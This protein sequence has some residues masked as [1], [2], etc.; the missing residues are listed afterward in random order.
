MPVQDGPDG[1]L[2]QAAVDRGPILGLAF[3]REPTP[4]HLS[5]IDGRHIGKYTAFQD[6]HALDWTLGLAL[7]RYIQVHVGSLPRDRDGETISIPPQRLAG[8]RAMTTVGTGDGSALDGSRSARRLA[9]DAVTRCWAVGCSRR[10]DRTD[11]FSRRRP[12]LAA[13]RWRSLT[14]ETIAVRRMRWARFVT[15]PSPGGATGDAR[16]SSTAPSV[17][18]PAPLHVRLGRRQ[19]NR[20]P[21]SI[22]AEAGV[23]LVYDNIDHVPDPAGHADGHERQQMANASEGGEQHVF[24]LDRICLGGPSGPVGQVRSGDSRR[25]RQRSCQSGCS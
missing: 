5:E 22:T 3:F 9:V 11:R 14:T 23:R 7:F 1:V 18:S 6:E 19:R 25:W 24:G 17:F 13:G 2:R 21:R 15:P 8:Q 20:T 10:H 12:S 16:V 4:D